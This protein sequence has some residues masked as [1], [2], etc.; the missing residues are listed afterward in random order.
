MAER[1]A[2]LPPAKEVRWTRRSLG[3][4]GQPRETPKQRQA[5]RHDETKRPSLLF[6]DFVFSWLI[7]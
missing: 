2:G 7:V 1:G 3:E 5:L 4:G 6:R